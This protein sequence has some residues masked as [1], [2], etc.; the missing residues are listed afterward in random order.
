VLPK[1]PEAIHRRVFADNALALYRRRGL[2]RNATE[3]PRE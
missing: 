1:L 2:E 3:A